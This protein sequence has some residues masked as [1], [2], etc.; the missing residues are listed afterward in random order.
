MYST[1]QC[2]ACGS[3]PGQHNVSLFRFPRN[4]GRC[5][6]WLERTG[7]FQLQGIP[8]MAI[9][10]KYRLCSVHFDSAQFRPPQFVGD[11]RKKLIRNALPTL[12]NGSNNRS[13]HRPRFRVKAETTG[14]ERF[15]DDCNSGI[16]DWS[17][18]T[19]ELQILA[20]HLC[21]LCAN[22]SED[23]VE[24]FGE[25]GK[26]LDLCNKIHTHLPIMVTEQDALP[27]RC[28]CSC[29]SK[30]EMCHKFVVSCLDANSKLCT[31]L[32]LPRTSDDEN[33]GT[34]LMLGEHIGPFETVVIEK[35]SSLA[36]RFNEEV[37]VHPNISESSLLKNG[38]DM[39]KNQTNIVS[40]RVL[41]DNKN[42]NIRGSSVMKVAS[43]YEERTFLVE[44]KQEMNKQL[45]IANVCSYINSGK[46]KINKKRNLQRKKYKKSKFEVALMK[47]KK[48]YSSSL[49]V[50]PSKGQRLDAKDVFYW[51]RSL[52]KR[53]WTSNSI[54]CD[55]CNL[56]FMNLNRLRSHR[57]VVHSRLHF[58]CQ[59]CSKLFGQQNSLKQ[60]IAIHRKRYTC[61]ICF[62]SL[63]TYQLML[64]H[65]RS[66]IKKAP[67]SSEIP[68]DKDLNTVPCIPENR[69]TNVCITPETTKT[70]ESPA[71]VKIESETSIE[72]VL[73]SEVLNT[74]KDEQSLPETGGETTIYEFSD[75]RLSAA[76]DPKVK[77]VESSDLTNNRD[78]A[79]QKFHPLTE[80][81]APLLNI[82]TPLS[83]GIDRRGQIFQ[84][85][86]IVE[87]VNSIKEDSLQYEHQICQVEYD[88]TFVDHSTVHEIV[89][90]VDSEASNNSTEL[91]HCST[92]NKIFTTELAYRNHASK[93]S[94]EKKFVCGTCK[95]PF[96]HQW[97]LDSHLRIH[98]DEKPFACNYCGE[99]FLFKRS[100]VVHER[101]HTENKSF[102][103]NVCDKCFN[104]VTRLKQ[105]IITHSDDWPF[106]CTF[107]SKEFRRR[108]ALKNHVAK[109]TDECK[110]CN[111]KPDVKGRKEGNDIL[112]EVAD[113][114]MEEP[115]S[116]S[117]NTIIFGEFG[118]SDIVI[119]SHAD[120]TPL[121]NDSNVACEYVI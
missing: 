97:A 35:E 72:T 102:K 111:H 79:E 36:D 113:S 65:R 2:V 88:S 89:T 81:E 94:M 17:E 1:N 15:S 29:I 41:N 5:R 54:R 115:G 40:S 70:E 13:R 55:G 87:A 60:H 33:T 42:D 74:S 8:A 23:L 32:R 63:P 57:A 92:C 51:N 56:L 83:G 106:R 110:L 10:E 46:N 96:A 34:S 3:K 78:E 69:D 101:I 18:T 95:R 112:E 118:S 75:E 16:A 104:S 108:E 90:F 48:V 43:P 21:R 93:H 67:N 73:G 91:Y 121:I 53:E 39:S 26:K 66:H 82:I 59:M 76:T 27:T 120:S 4:A 50:S 52:Q 11:Q 28:C 100:L 49:T 77:F 103:C 61:K 80:V 22:V 31:I 107:C 19:E 105:H 20:P 9:Y 45:V 109:H 71:Q 25:E 14:H 114:K 85:P 119:E 24:V 6:L 98:S 116:S 84:E 58:K 12:F 30:L 7:L 62:E 37:D 86:E 47:L 44:G 68:D 38:T 99:K 64:S 117:D